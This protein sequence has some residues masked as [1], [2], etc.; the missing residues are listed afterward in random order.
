[1]SKMSASDLI[2]NALLELL[3]EKPY[4]EITV[5]ELINK[6]GVARVSFYRN[7]H[8]MSDVIDE[9]T[10]DIT[11]HFAEEVYPVIS[12]NDE[13]AWREFL[14]QHFYRF[15]KHHSSYSIQKFQNGYVLFS[16]I[17]TKI[18]E[19]E[20]TLPSDTLKQKYAVFGK[21]GIINNIIKKWIDEGM[22]ET[23]EEMIDYIMSFILLF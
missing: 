4:V 7:F 13:R 3:N 16:R 8:S 9:I 18:Q 19:L 22:T 14:F 11:Q 6:A 15:S 17:N 1:M 10:N 20:K 21:M 2:K 12:G 23:P 5:S